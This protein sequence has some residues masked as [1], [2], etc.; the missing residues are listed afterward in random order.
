MMPNRPC[1]GANDTEAPPT[2]VRPGD[3]RR[4][5]WLSNLDGMPYGLVAT[6]WPSVVAPRRQVLRISGV[7]FAGAGGQRRCQGRAGGEEALAQ[8]IAPTGC[9][10]P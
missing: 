2:R 7:A 6:G 9:Q 10:R 5:S 4:S 1:S 8:E 3:S